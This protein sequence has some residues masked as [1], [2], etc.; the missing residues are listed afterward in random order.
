MTAFTIS[1]VQIHANNNIFSDVST[2]PGG[3]PNVFAQT[4][5]V[6]TSRGNV[7]VLDD[8]ND[9][10]D[11]DVPTPQNNQ[12]YQDGIAM[13]EGL[14]INSRLIYKEYDGSMFHSIPGH[15]SP[16]MGQERSVKPY[17]RIPTTQP[18]VFVASLADDGINH[19]QPTTIPIPKFYKHYTYVPGSSPPQLVLHNSNFLEY[20]STRVYHGDVRASMQGSDGII[21]QGRGQM[22]AKLRD[23]SGYTVIFDGSLGGSGN[24]VQLTQADRDYTMPGTSGL[25]TQIPRGYFSGVFDDRRVDIPSS[26][27]HTFLLIRSYAGDTMRISGEIQRDMDFIKIDDLPPNTAYRITQ[28]TN[29]LAVGITSPEGSIHIPSS[30]ISSLQALSD[31]ALATLGGSLLLYPGALVYTES[32]AGDDLSPAAPQG[33]LVFDNL[34]LQAQRIPDG[35]LGTLYHTHAYVKIPII[36]NITVTDVSL[37]GI[38]PLDHLGRNY[39]INHNSIFVPIIPPYKTIFLTINGIPTQLHIADVLGGTGL[40]IA[41]P[42]TNTI[43]IS[44]ANNFVNSIEAVVGTT[45]YMVAATDGNAK[46]HIRA[47]VSGVSEITNTRTYTIPPPPPPPPRPID[48]LTTWV[49]VY[50]NGQIQTIAGQTKTQIFFSDSPATNHASGV[51]ETSSFHTARFAYPDVVVLDTVSVPVQEADFV[52]FYFYNKIYAEGS[53]PPLPSTAIESGRMGT[54]SASVT[55]QHAS[56]NTSL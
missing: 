24:R 28:N 52:E 9:D 20:T 36:S 46:A 14:G 41:N 55:I 16:L 12:T 2:Q 29:T 15:S 6:V 23:Y 51:A 47:T 35:S 37:D 13:I 25:L 39:T 32:R 56:I 48:P 34:N 40:K 53:I 5:H 11:D 18:P 42:V 54:A 30:H 44:R 21:I 10:D 7:F 49:E 31:P 27:P 3:I 43:A 1:A 33:T 45:T 17:M 50:V 4:V 26:K 38:V 19:L 8:F 22:L